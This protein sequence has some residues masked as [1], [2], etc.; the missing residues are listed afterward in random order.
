MADSKAD[1][2]Y[3]EEARERYTESSDAWSE[4]RDASLEDRK[5]SRLSDQWPEE[6]LSPYNQQ[7]A[8]LYS[9][10]CQR[11]TAE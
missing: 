8:S 2:D 4:V 11:C 7:N 6:V 10:D 3:I 5:F 9:P 1:S